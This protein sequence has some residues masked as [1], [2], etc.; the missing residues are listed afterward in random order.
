M[1]VLARFKFIAA[2]EM[3]SVNPWLGARRHSTPEQRV[4]CHPP[5]ADIFDL[6]FST[7]QLDEHES[8][9]W[10]LPFLFKRGDR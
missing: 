5:P 10:C 1:T 8:L 7:I 9:V 4:A 3:W 2:R 6:K